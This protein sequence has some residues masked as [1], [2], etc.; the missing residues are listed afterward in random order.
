MATCNIVFVIIIICCKK[1]VE[2][3]TKIC[4]CSLW[5]HFY[6]FTLNDMIVVVGA[7]LRLWRILMLYFLLSSIKCFNVY[8][9]FEKEGQSQWLMVEQSGWLVES[10]T[11]LQCDMDGRPGRMDE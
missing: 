3:M 10:L 4:V 5:R 1:S 6:E 9:T 11:K 8:A 7:C 2:K